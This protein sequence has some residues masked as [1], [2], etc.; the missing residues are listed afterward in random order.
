MSGKLPL[1]PKKLPETS[2]SRL[3]R[4]VFADLIPRCM[5]FSIHT[6]SKGLA[7]KGYKLFKKIFAVKNKKKKSVRLGIFL[8]IFAGSVGGIFLLEGR[9]VSHVFPD[10]GLNWPSGRE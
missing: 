10:S 4:S 9:K 5:M 1:T 7:G 3:R 2:K 6:R 8:W